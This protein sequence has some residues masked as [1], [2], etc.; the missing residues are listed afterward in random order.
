MYEDYVPHDRIAGLLIIHEMLALCCAVLWGV[1]RCLLCDKE[2]TTKHI[3]RAH[4]TK[5]SP[6]AAYSRLIRHPFSTHES[7]D[8]RLCLSDLLV[9]GDPIL[10]VRPVTL[11]RIA[12]THL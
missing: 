2:H 5:V 7:S 4:L 10:A 8:I 12:V 3:M 11:S 9:I 1:Q 6:D